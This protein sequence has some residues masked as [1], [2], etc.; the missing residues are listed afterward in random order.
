MFIILSSYCHYDHLDTSENIQHTKSSHSKIA[1]IRESDLPFVSMDAYETNDN[2][3]PSYGNYYNCKRISKYT[4]I[5]E[6]IPLEIILSTDISFC[7]H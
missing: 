4:S 1:V 2:I 7:I 5:D 6:Y 3:P